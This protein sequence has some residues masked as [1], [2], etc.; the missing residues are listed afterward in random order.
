MNFDNELMEAWV[1]FS[2]NMDKWTNDTPLSAG[3][4]DAIQGTQGPS[5]P[6]REPF[7]QWVRDNRD[8]LI[9]YHSEL[10]TKP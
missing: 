9:A 2:T 8:D 6:Q 5:G 3:L 4:L 10:L 1:W 7:Y